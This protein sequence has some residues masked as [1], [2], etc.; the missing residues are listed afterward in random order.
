MAWQ[1][2][3][4][5]DG[6]DDLAPD[7]SEIRLLPRLERASMV[8]CRLGPGQVT[9][10][11]CHRTVDELW[12]CLS[13]AGQLWRRDGQAEDVVDLLPGVAVSIPVGTAFQFRAAA[14]GPLELL[15]ATVPAWP[16]PEEAV[17]LD[18]RWTP[19]VRDVR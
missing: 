18:G 17:P 6:Y 16:G 12:Y 3:T 5:G 10:A 13:G 4:V 8:H 19:A 7:G 15:I 1:T 14:A 9:R 2:R 11:V